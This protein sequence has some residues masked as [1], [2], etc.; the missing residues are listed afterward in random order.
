MYVS[1]IIFILY[2]GIIIALTDMT[3]LTCSKL[4][5]LKQS[6]LDRPKL[7]ECDSLF[8]KTCITTL[9]YHYIKI[10]TLQDSFES[11]LVLSKNETITKIQS[12]PLLPF[13]RNFF[14]KKQ[15][16]SSNNKEKC[17]TNINVNQNIST[18]SKFN[19]T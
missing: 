4:K 19:R 17:S 15:K 7:S 6:E 18:N 12:R 9:R 2:T 5:S 1:K 8:T 3:K 13:P 14:S 11:F 10:Y 16:S